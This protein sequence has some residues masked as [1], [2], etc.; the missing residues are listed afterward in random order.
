MLSGRQ[1]IVMLSV[2]MPWLAACGDSKE[3]LEGLIQNYGY[4]AYKTPLQEAGTGTLVGGSPSTLSLIAHQHTCFPE[5]LNDEKTALRQRD[6]STLPS[7]S[8]RVSIKGGAKADVLP[9][10]SLLGNGSTNV[11]LQEV[12]RVDVEFNGVHVEYMDSIKLSQFYREKMTDICKDY[13][14]KVGF[15]I[16]A[17]R[18]DQMKLEFF[19]ENQQQIELSAQT[20]DNI[21]DMNQGLNWTIEHNSTLVIKT[22]RYFGYQL[23]TLKRSDQGLA[24][25][26]A[27]T[28]EADR[29]IFES[30]D[31]FTHKLDAA[32]GSQLGAHPAQEFYWTLAAL[33]GLAFPYD[34][35]RVAN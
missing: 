17:I 11:Q 8:Q 16:Q 5:S 29:F 2:L 23:G 1:R 32:S 27:T 33:P 35:S 30:M 28:T 3:Y 26:R 20:V 18:I 34:Y 9:Q 15:I 22:P 25:Y 14:D 7:T 13:L 10:L 24:I 12:Q 31:I 4:I 19:K 6:Y 21:L